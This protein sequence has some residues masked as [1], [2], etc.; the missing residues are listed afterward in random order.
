MHLENNGK[1]I[2]AKLKAKGINIF[3]IYNNFYCNNFCLD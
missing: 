3:V 1:K 2:S